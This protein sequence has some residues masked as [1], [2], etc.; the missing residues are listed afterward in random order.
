M[1]E[2]QTAAR[3]LSDGNLSVRVADYPDD[4]I[5]RLAHTFNEMAES[6][7]KEDEKKKNSLRMFRTSLEHR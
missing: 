7:E 5:G 1:K 3:D 6:I 4:E 2:M